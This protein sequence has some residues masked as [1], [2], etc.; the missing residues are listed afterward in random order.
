MSL[1]LGTN[2]NALKKEETAV[3]VTYISIAVNVFMAAAKFITGILGNSFA[4]VADAIESTTD[5]VASVF[6]MLG[7]KISIKPPDKEH[8]Y[9]HGRAETLST[10]AIVGF[11]VFSAIF[12][13]INS[14]KKIY[15]HHEL[16]EPYTLL[17]LA[18]VVAIKEYYYHYIKKKG[19][20]TNS[21]TLQ[22]DAWHHRSDAI[23]SLTAFVGISISLI[24]GEGYESAD[25]WAALLAAGIILYNAYVILHPA[26]SE[27]LDE[28]RHEE[29]VNDIKQL[30]KEV[31]G[32]EYIEKCY[33]RKSGMNYLVDLHLTVD[34]QLTVSQGHG[35]AHRLKDAIQL[36]MPDV[37]DVLIHVEP[38]DL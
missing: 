31:E 22:A 18:I 38:D 4:L 27:I 23:T 17:V 19:K 5:V 7:V 3:K 1:I 34:G 24:M 9:G 8:P 14:I 15:T 11:L 28:N 32:V 6:V 10:I 26:I 36:Q 20:E 16:P 30:S 29:V 21:S 2:Q 35:I 37:A 13:I 25:D 12:I 33:V